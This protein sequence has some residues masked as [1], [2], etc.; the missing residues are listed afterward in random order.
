MGETRCFTCVNQS[1]AYSNFIKTWKKA[2]Q[3]QKKEKP[4]SKSAKSKKHK[5][6]ITWKKR[7]KKESQKGETWEKNGLVHLHF[8]CMYCA[9][10]FYFVFAFCFLFSRQKAKTKQ[11]KSK[12]T[13]RESNIYAKKMQMDKSFF[14]H[15]FS[16]FDVPFFHHLF[17]SV[18]FSFEVVLFD[19]QC[20]FLFCIFFNFKNN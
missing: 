4:K 6:T 2:R 3:K 10:S 14:P 11:N 1:I 20:V 19:F 12:K 18:F 7:E 16:L 15:F 8:F 17:G 9:F 5:S 13:N